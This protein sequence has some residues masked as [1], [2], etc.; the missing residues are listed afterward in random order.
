MERLKEPSTRNNKVL[1][2]LFLE[3][4]GLILKTRYEKSVYWSNF[5]LGQRFL[6]ISQKQNTGQEGKESACLAFLS[7]LIFLISAVNTCCTK[8]ADTRHKTR[9]LMF[10]QLQEK[11]CQT[12]GF[13]N[14]SIYALKIM[15]FG[16]PSLCFLFFNLPGCFSVTFLHLRACRLGI[17]LTYS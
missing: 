5:W 14:N 10:V 15:R 13:K 8:E 7:A 3:T 2:Q 11:Y 9:Y 12:N 17:Y 1:L 4:Q 16:T 6:V